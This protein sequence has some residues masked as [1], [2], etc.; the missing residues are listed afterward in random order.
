MRARTAVLLVILVALGIFTAVNWP[1]IATPTPLH[2]VFAR[3]EAP[4]GIVLLGGTAGV[5]V[6]YA[7]VLSWVE[8]TALLEARRYAR[9]LQ[10]QRQLAESA[11][12]SR[13]AELKA[14]LETELA[15]LRAL[16]ERVSQDLSTRIDRVGDQLQGEIERTGNTLAAHFGELEDRLNRGERPAPPRSSE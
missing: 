16:P 7:L 10:A 3:V 6:R 2:L 12:A 9:E 14:L 11:E 4:L 8:T 15:A 1:V 5:T 13:Y